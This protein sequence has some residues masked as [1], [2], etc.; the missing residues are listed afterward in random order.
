MGVGGEGLF[1]CGNH[2][3]TQVFK[4]F[5]LLLIKLISPEFAMAKH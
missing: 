3:Q 4:S 5:D 1:Q 2:L